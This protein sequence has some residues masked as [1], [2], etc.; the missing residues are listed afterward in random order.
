MNRTPPEH[1]K[2][3][4]GT[5]AAEPVVVTNNVKESYGDVV[6][7]LVVTYRFIDES[8]APLTE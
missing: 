6:I 1:S 8:N 3:V 5:Q 2:E 7:A 4:V